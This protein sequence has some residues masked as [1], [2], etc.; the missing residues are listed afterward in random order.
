MAKPITNKKPKLTL[1]R[2]TFAMKRYPQLHVHV[3][4]QRQAVWTGP[5]RPTE[6]SA[7]YTLRITYVFGLRPII[8]I[9][10]PMLA[11]APGQDHIPHTYDGQKDICVHLRSEWNPGLLIADTIM[12]WISQWLYFYEIWVVTEKWFGKGTH[13][14]TNQHA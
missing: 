2:Q 12:P 10:S 14:G 6:M 8:E 9:I 4:R 1:V 7:T 3:A 13:S 11:L 5:W